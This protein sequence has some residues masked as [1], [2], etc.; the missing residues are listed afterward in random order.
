MEFGH[1]GIAAWSHLKREFTAG[2]V[3][4]SIGIFIGFPFDLIKVKLQAFPNKYKSAVDC[5]KQS[6]KQDGWLGMINSLLF[7]GES[8][9]MR[10]LQPELKDGE[11][12]TPLNT[13]LAGCAGGILQCIVLVPS[14]VVKCSMQ[15]DLQA[16]A[17]SHN[18]FKETMSCIRKIHSV[19]GFRG[20]Y[21]GFSVTAL[22]EA[23][24][25]GIYFF[26]YKFTREMLTKIQGLDRAN[27]ISITLAG[28]VAG[29]LSWALLYPID[30]V[31]THIQIASASNP[32]SPPVG[33]VAPPATATGILRRALST[34]K[35]PAATSLQDM[36]ILQ[37]ARLLHKQYGFKV[38]TR[39][40]GTTVLRAFPVNASTFYFYELV[41]RELHLS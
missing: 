28:G 14:D 33:T 17:K 41:K 21:K 37:V 10:A 5:F 30:V 34:S 25:I 11:V 4:G 39:G 36:S 19:E 26:A 29:A 40:M 8:L 12:G 2:G 15:A 22:R 38:F 27:H 13:F 32:S 1:D 31:K 3:A 23:P 35:S 20:F 6:V 24:S 16:G 9:A 7:V 18:A